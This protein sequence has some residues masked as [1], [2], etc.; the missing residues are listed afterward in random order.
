MKCENSYIQRGVSSSEISKQDVCLMIQE[1]KKKVALC[2]AGARDKK[3]MTVNKKTV[4]SKK[5]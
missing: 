3:R 5:T 4:F 1:T 2:S